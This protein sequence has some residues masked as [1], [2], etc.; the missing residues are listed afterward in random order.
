MSRALS[1][2]EKSELPAVIKRRLAGNTK[3]AGYWAARDA[4]P[5]FGISLQEAPKPV[6]SEAEK[7]ERNERRNRRKRV[8]GNAFKVFANLL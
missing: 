4:A 3:G 5:K 7:E 6:L 1:S 8:E 2:Y